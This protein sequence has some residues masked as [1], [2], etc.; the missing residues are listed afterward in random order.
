MG[1]DRKRY[2]EY[3]GTATIAPMSYAEWLGVEDDKE[4]ANLRA[5]IAELEEALRPFGKVPVSWM[6]NWAHLKNISIDDFVHA[7]VVLNKSE[8]K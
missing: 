4:I 5:R 2:E 6:G 3:R 1:A 8:T 7:S